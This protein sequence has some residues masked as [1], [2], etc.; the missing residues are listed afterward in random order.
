MTALLPAFRVGDAVTARVAVPELH[1]PAGATLRV[2]RIG[3]AYR[4]GHLYRLSGDGCALA[5]LF[6]DELEAT[7]D[8]N[9]TAS[10]GT[11]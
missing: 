8:A 7:S 1:V 6:E 4:W 9:I 11:P 2:D 5:V 10:G 3:G